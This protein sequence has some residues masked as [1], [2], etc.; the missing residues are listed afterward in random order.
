MSKRKY[1][2]ETELV[3]TK[4]EEEK[5]SSILEPLLNE[6]SLTPAHFI[7]GY[8]LK[9]IPSINKPDRIIKI[10]FGFFLLS[11]DVNK[12]YKLYLDLHMHGKQEVANIIKKYACTDKSQSV[13]PDD[14]ILNNVFTDKMKEKIFQDCLEAHQRLKD[15][16]V[17]N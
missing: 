7:V 12:D 10:I 1:Y 15:N 9:G 5:M 13:N 16:G 17:I 14:Y 6:Y 3:L 4:D 11:A 2:D 8:G